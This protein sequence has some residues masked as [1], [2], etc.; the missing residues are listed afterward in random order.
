MTFACYGK[1][2][3]AN[4]SLSETNSVSQLCVIFHSVQILNA[5]KIDRY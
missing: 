3:L 2:V 4:P 1:V 5:N